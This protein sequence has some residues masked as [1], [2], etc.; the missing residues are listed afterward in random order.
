MADNMTK[1]QKLQGL[2]RIASL[3]LDQQ[4]LAL[5]MAEQQRQT[6]LDMIASLDRCDPQLD[7]SLQS[8]AK[9]ALLYQAWADLRRKDLNTK[10]Q[11]QTAIVL[12]KQDSARLAFGKQSVLQSLP[13]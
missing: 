10:L 4:L 6:T 7:V 12:A 5:R 1:D 9:A 13:K 11:Q 8:A 3:L 2:Q